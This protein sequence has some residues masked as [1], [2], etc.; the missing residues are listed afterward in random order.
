MYVLPVNSCSATDF[1]AASA[2][3]FDDNKNKESLQLK[4]TDVNTHIIM[5][6]DSQIETGITKHTLAHSEPHTYT[7]QEA[8]SVLLHMAVTSATYSSA[9]PYVSETSDKSFL[10]IL[11]N[12]SSWIKLRTTFLNNT[13]SDNVVRVNL[14]HSLMYIASDE[15]HVLGSCHTRP[16]I[17]HIHPCTQHCISKH[18]IPYNLYTSAVLS[19]PAA[20]SILRFYLCP[21]TNGRVLYN[22]TYA[23]A[24]CPPPDSVSSFSCGKIDTLSSSNLYQS[25]SSSATVAA[26]CAIDELCS[27]R[28]LTNP[29]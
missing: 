3:L 26:P 24:S 5:L 29:M 11:I 23:D 1:M 18:E 16:T 21:H 20:I 27:A 28:F 19:D 2:S 7:Q 15:S 10:V 25:S 4:H 8:V 13:K 9:G 6:E 14:S 22:K 12:A 17:T